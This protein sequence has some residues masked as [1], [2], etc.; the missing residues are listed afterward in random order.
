MMNKFFDG[1]FLSYG[2]RVL[3]FSDVPQEERIDPMI[4]VF[5]RV[6][7]CIFH[8]YGASGTIQRHDSLCILPL[9]IVNEKTYIFIWF[10]YNL[11]LVLLSCLMLY[12]LAIVFAPSLRSRLLSVSARALPMEV[13][14]RINCKIKLGDWWILYVLSSNVDSLV[15]KDMIMEL[16]KRMGSEGPRINA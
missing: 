6:T 16:T 5:P 15:Y 7:K 9:N 14:Q 1:E 4:Y 2:L 13:C 11:L 12:R 8:K 10:W 3:Q